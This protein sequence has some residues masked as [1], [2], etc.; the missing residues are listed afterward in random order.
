LSA[1]VAWDG[2]ANPSLG[3][4]QNFWRSAEN[5]KVSNKWKTFTWAVSQSSPIRSIE[6]DG[7]LILG[8]KGYA[9]GGFMANMNVSGKIDGAT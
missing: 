6:V 7:D 1:L 5:V 4:L 2:S 9:S 8:D 3:A